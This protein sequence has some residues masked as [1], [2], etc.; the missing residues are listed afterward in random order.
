VQSCHLQDITVFVSTET[1]SITI[2]CRGSEPAGVATATQCDT[3]CRHGH[4]RSDHRSTTASRHQPR[5]QDASKGYN[6][7]CAA[8]HVDC[9]LEAVVNLK[10]SHTHHFKEFECLKENQGLLSCL[11]AYVSPV[12]SPQDNCQSDGPV[13][14]QHFLN[15]TSGR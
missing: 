14:K 6:I 10:I 2:S 8:L 9:R 4:I 5:R 12:I 7:T 13:T 11:T 3:R 15:V 1:E